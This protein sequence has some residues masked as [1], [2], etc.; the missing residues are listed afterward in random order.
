MNKKNVTKGTSFLLILLLIILTLYSANLRFSGNAFKFFDLF[1][2]NAKTDIGNC[3][4]EISQEGVCD[5]KDSPGKEGGDPVPNPE[6]K[7]NCDKMYGAGKWHA[8]GKGC[9]ANTDTCNQKN[10]NAPPVCCP[11]DTTPGSTDFGGGLNYCDKTNEFCQWHDGGGYFACG[12]QC[13]SPSQKCNK[14]WWPYRCVS[15]NKCQTGEFQCG[16]INEGILGGK[17]YICCKE[18]KED[19]VDFGDPPEQGRYKGCVPKGQDSCEQDETYCKGVEGT[20]FEK[21]ALCCHSD[22]ICAKQPNGAPYCY[23][24]KPRP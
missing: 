23:Q 12:T 10:E 8:C 20:K 22:E 19:C 3:N 21:A 2:Q 15:D 1:Q 13:C 6:T 4:N 9:C 7:K 17:D 11:P 16:K 14:L 18:G 24:E 5:D